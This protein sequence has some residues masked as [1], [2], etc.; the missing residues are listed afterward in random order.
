VEVE[1]AA[2]LRETRAVDEG[3]KR[4][5]PLCT[6]RRH[7]AIIVLRLMQ[8]FQLRHIRSLRNKKNLRDARSIM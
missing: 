6:H 4:Q 1:C 7:K 2:V 5:K 8:L 3:L